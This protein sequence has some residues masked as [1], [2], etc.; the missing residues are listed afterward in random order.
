MLLVNNAWDTT[1]QEWIGDS[2]VRVGTDS[3]AYS[4]AN[5]MVKNG[6]VDGGI[7][8]LDLVTGDHISLRRN[9]ENPVWGGEEYWINEIRVYE[10]PNLISYFSSQ[11]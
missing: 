10:V 3:S 6:I 9:E 4:T 2:H 7:F 8:K 1:T 11:V 5:T